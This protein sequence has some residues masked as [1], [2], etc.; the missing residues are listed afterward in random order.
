MPQNGRTQHTRAVT[1]RD[2]AKA[3]DVSQSTVSRVLSDTSG[4]VPISQDTKRR[5]LNA[6]EELG[7]HRNLHAGSLRS[8]KTQMLAMMVADISN[9]FY[10]PMVRGV[11]DVARSRGYDVMLSNTDHT[12]EGELSFCDS[13]IRR[14]VDGVILAPYHLTSDDIDRLMERTGAVISAL[15]QHIEHPE[16]D[17]VYGADD[18]ATIEAV[19][20]LARDKHHRRIG[21][22]GVTDR[23]AAGFRRR[24]AYQDALNN[25]GIEVPDSYFQEGDWSIESGT[26]AMEALLALDVPPTAVLALN[27]LMAIGAMESAERSGVR[28]PEEIAIVGFDNIPASSWVRPKL[29]TIAQYPRQIG[30]ALAT[31]VFERLD[32]YHGAGRRQEISVQ[33]IPR[34]TT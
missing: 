29:T 11:Q 10:H 19:Q 26:A 4:A 33:L 31:A 25:L 15:G 34:E 20:W 27:D 22:I 28:I 1:M 5:V 14:P 30:E 12:R 6:V 17:V 13:I 23:F 18:V 21:L 3:A 2:V 24:C 9:P 32:G 16:V 8:K 7:Y